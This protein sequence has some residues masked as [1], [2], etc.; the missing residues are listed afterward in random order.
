MLGS[1]CVEV[2][3]LIALKERP[4]NSNI[5]ICQYRFLCAR[6]LIFLMPCTPLIIEGN[7]SDIDRQL[8]LLRSASVLAERTK[9][10]VGGNGRSPTFDYT[11]ARV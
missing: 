5:T 4:W 9:T 2:L 1:R 7:W 11:S 8:M 10:Y 3:L 6:L